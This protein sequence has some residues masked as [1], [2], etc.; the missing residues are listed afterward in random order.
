MSYSASAQES[1][2]CSTPLGWTANLLGSGPLP[3]GCLVCS[4]LYWCFKAKVMSISLGKWKQLG[5]GSGAALG[6]SIFLQMWAPE[7][8]TPPLTQCVCFH[9][10]MHVEVHLQKYKHWVCVRSTETERTSEL[11]EERCRRQYCIYYCLLLRSA[12]WRG[13]CRSWNSV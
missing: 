6:R 5:M 9:N 8:N 13:S 7:S 2:P 1:F 3:E 11:R 12:L 10:H 4:K